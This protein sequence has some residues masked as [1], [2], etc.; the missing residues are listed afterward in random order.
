VL[1]QRRRTE[2]LIVLGLFA[3]AQLLGW[4]VLHSVRASLGL[5]L[6]SAFVLPVVL[7]LAFDR[8]SR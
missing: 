7:T 4:M 5:L 1:A 3:L 6:F 2:N 8:R